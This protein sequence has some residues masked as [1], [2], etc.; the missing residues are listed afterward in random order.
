MWG[1][2]RGSVGVSDGPLY[3]AEP[4][5][6]SCGILNTFLFFLI[7]F[8]VYLFLRERET[9]HKQGRGREREIQNLKQAPGSEL[10]AQSLT[11]DL[12]PQT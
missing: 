8:N 11:Q 9:E 4:P 12:N 1:A 5:L 2:T 10:S 6:N 3:V 7:F